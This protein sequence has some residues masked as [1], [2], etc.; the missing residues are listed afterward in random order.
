MKYELNALT[1]ALLAIARNF[2]GFGVGAPAN[3]IEETKAIE[4]ASS[5]L[6]AAL[7]HIIFRVSRSAGRHAGAFREIS[8]D[9]AMSNAVMKQQDQ[10]NLDGFEGYE[11]EIEGGDDQPAVQSN[12]GTK[13][14]FTLQAAWDPP[15]TNDLIALDVRRVV[16]K[17]GKERDKPPLETI[18]LK[19]GERWPDIAAMNNACPRSEWREG[20]NGELVGPWAGQHIVIFVDPETMVRYWWPSPITTIG[21]ARCVRDLVD[22]TRLMRRFKRQINLY[23]VVELSHTHMPTRFRGR[24]RPHLIVKKWIVLGP[25]DDKVLP[26]PDNTPSLSGSA[27]EK[28][29]AAAGKV[30]DQLKTVEPPTRKEE[31]EDEIPF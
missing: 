16:N 27:T 3:F 8:G 20:F 12:L 15:V 22:Q 23:P 19:P 25:D 1:P 13:L 18:E 10:R 4:R 28:P 21:S 26:A 24:E 2:A 31:L 9:V 11:D 29:P 17:W 14:V 5:P 30:I 6:G 7:D